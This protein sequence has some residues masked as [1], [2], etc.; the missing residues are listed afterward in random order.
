MEAFN[1]RRDDRICEPV[2]GE[3]DRSALLHWLNHLPTFRTDSSFFA[4]DALLVGKLKD[5]PDELRLLVLLHSYEC[6]SAVY[7]SFDF[8]EKTLRPFICEPV[9]ERAVG[10]Q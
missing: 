9:R 1:R 5:T 6:E 8:P 7:F 3:L 10:G 4:A 2:R